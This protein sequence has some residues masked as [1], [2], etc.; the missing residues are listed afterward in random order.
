[1]L[2]FI[3]LAAAAFLGLSAISADVV[4]APN[5]NIS[6]DAAGA[7][8]IFA[9]IVENA[10]EDCREELSGDAFANFR[11]QSCVEAKVSRDVAQAGP[12]RLAEYTAA[13]PDYLA[14]ALAR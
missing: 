1:M 7:D 8:L 13:H 11:L 9:Q 14:T 5:N 2:H 10:L 4:A 6:L 12:S 3:S